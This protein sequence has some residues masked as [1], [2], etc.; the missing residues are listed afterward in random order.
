MTRRGSAP[1]P[2]STAAPITGAAADHLLFTGG[3]W[4][5][6]ARAC[7]RAREGAGPLAAPPLPRAQRTRRIRY[8]KIPCTAGLTK[9]SSDSTSCT[10]T[11]RAPPSSAEISERA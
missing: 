1:A 10:P 5:L 9:R 6:D 11:A 8:G 3:A 2:A 4:Y 7:E